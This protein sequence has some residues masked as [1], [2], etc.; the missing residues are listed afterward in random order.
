[1][2]T[3]AILLFVVMAFPSF[4]DIGEETYVPFDQR[5]EAG[6]G[7]IG[8][9]QVTLG[10]ATHENLFDN[11]PWQIWTASNPAA[12]GNQFLNLT[13]TG[14]ITFNNSLPAAE[15][16]VTASWCAAGW[17][18]GSSLG[19]QFG[20]TGVTE[21][22]NESPGAMHYIY[23]PST[24]GVPVKFREELIGPGMGPGS[25]FT[26]GGTE[27]GTPYT[28]GSHPGVFNDGNSFA[29]SIFLAEGN[30]VV[31]TIEENNFNNYGAAMFYGLYFT[32]IGPI[33]E[34]ASVTLLGLGALLLLHRRRKH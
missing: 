15:Y 8:G 27:S 34:P 31:L 30:Q 25:M 21:A 13:G 11:A 18:N 1:M 24:T 14:T 9:P 33:P 32:E 16:T 7:P 29:T 3:V 10:G 17:A 6:G 28:L 23:P 12:A 2:K 26:D 22:G 4:A 20:G 19:L 5:S